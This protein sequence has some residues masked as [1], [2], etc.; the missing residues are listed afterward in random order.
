VSSVS[1]KNRVAT[2]DTGET[3]V[4]RLPEN[5]TTGYRWAIESCGTLKSAGDNFEPGGEAPGSAGI[6]SFQ[7]TAVPGTHPV[8]L[9][10]RREWEA[11]DQAIDHFAM[12]VRV[13]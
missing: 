12:N 13:A 4:I 7:W 10:L 5:P 11:A 3:I 8:S 1:D 6:R 2:V 9:A